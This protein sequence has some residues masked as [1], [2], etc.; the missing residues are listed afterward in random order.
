MSA[1][2]TLPEIPS[3]SLGADMSSSGWSEDSTAY[4]EE[5]H[6]SPQPPEPP[7]PSGK[8]TRPVSSQHQ[9]QA[10]RDVQLSGDELLALWGRVGVHVGEAAVALHEKSKRALIGDGTFPGFVNAVIGHVPQAAPATP[11]QDGFSYGHLVYAQTGNTVQKRMSDIMPGDVIF[12]SEAKLKGHKGLQTYHQTVGVGGEP[13]VGIVC[14]F[15]VKKSKVKVYQANQHVG[16]QTVEMVSYRLEDLKSGNV[17][18]RR[19]SLMFLFLSN[20][21]FQVFRVAE[22]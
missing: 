14:E 20:I 19:L 16:G 12:L 4:R 8:P 6:G 10:P 1:Q 7:T 13:V 21:Q 3:G 5:A 11:L 2:W 9:Q 17:K 18:A 15:E 22:A